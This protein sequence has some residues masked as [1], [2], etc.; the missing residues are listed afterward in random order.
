MAL[1]NLWLAT[2]E[3]MVIPVKIGISSC[4]LGEKVRYDGGHKHDRYI[5]DTLGNF[6]EFIGVCPEV[7]CGLP[8][9]REAMRLEGDPATPRLV[10]RNTRIDL[11]GQVRAWCLNK[12]R[13][14]EMGELCGFIFK[15]KSPSCGPFQVKVHTPGIS[16]RSGRGL[17][18]DAVARHFPLLPVEDEERLCNMAIRENFMERVVAC[19]RWRDFLRDEPE[20]GDLLEFHIRHKLLVMAHSPA[21]CRE[22]GRLV[23]Q[24]NEA[25]WGELL[26][27]YQE[28]LMQALSL[29]ATVSKNF[30]VLLH[31]MGHFKGQLSSGEKGSLLEAIGRYRDRQAP[32]LVPLTLLMHFANEYDQHYLRKQAYLNPHPL[33]LMLR[34]HG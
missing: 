6:V 23:A 22:M 15:K 7:E 10:T 2:G 34:N 1:W 18:A 4:L 5:T 24:A 30:N 20:T 13:E 9:P 26:D 29:H 3:N 19:R 28:L 21:H 8:I 31:V 33:E 11:T 17:F 16:A 32:L 14:P 27:R 12:V 25:R